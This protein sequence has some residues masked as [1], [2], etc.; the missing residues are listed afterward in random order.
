VVGDRSLIE[1]IWHNIEVFRSE[2]HRIVR[3]ADIDSRECW[4]P[5]WWKIVDYKNC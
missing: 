4:K 2:P 3:L 5:Q 1:L